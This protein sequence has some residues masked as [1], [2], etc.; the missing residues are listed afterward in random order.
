MKAASLIIF[1]DNIFLGHNTSGEKLTPNDEN[2]LSGAESFGIR[3]GKSL[4]KG[5]ILLKLGIPK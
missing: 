5:F 2:L 1:F 4:R 3:F